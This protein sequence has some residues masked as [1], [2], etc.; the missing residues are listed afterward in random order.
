[1]S[2][3]PRADAKDKSFFRADLKQFGYIKNSG[4][5]EYSSLDFLSDELL[6]VTINQVVFYGT[7]RQS[8]STLV[9][10]DIHKKQAVRNTV[11]AVKASPRS[12]A[13]LTD[14]NFLLLSTSD[15]KLCSADLHC[16]KSF[17]TRGLV[18]ALDSDGLKLLE[19]ADTFVLR[20]DETSTNGARTVTSELRSTIWNKIRHP[21]DIDEPSPP[22]FRRITVYDNQSGKA[23]L[24]L[25][26]NPGNHLVGPALSPNGTKL[27]IVRGT[28]LEVYDVP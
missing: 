24:S 1:M 6:L 20:I 21:L 23:L 18:T 2:I 25:H 26:Y 11:M 16:E 19:G 14:G 13:P 27:A 7:T 8:P 17:P 5:A 28:V 10:F 15:V 4:T 3:Q 12:V 22:D 9:V